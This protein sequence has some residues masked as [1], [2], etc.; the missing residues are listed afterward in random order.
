MSVVFSA[1]GLNS[2]LL[3]KPLARTVYLA[4]PRTEEGKEKLMCVRQA[5]T[6]IATEAHTQMRSPIALGTIRVARIPPADASIPSPI[7]TG[8]EL[9]ATCC[10]GVAVCTVDEVKAG[11][12][13]VVGNVEAAGAQA[14]VVPEA[15]EVVVGEEFGTGVHEGSGPDEA[16]R[17]VDPPVAAKVEL[18]YVRNEVSPDGVVHQNWCAS[19][20]IG[21]VG[22][23][24]VM[25]EP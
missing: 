21:V 8:P 9:A 20:I 16:D 3:H 19:G 25:R 17:N 12:K 14:I 13:L 11:G 23:L 1:G 24:V 7:H 15:E 22:A 6:G 5:R 10:V 18:P 2:L 4:I